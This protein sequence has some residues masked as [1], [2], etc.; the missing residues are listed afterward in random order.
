MFSNEYAVHSAL[1]HNHETMDYRARGS[2]IGNARGRLRKVGY[3]GSDVTFNNLIFTSVDAKHH[4]A[5][6]SKQW[7]VTWV[8][9]NSVCTH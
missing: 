2:W 8:G 3:G 4:G 7:N 6:L 5:S 1:P 9:N